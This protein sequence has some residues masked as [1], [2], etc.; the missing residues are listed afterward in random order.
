M[1]SFNS[2]NSI[3]HDRDP[4]TV[5]TDPTQ[6]CVET[7]DDA[8]KSGEIVAGLRSGEVGILY[9]QHGVGKTALMQ[10]L[11]YSLE[12]GQP[13]VPLTRAP[14]SPLKVCILTSRKAILSSIR[15]TRIRS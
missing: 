11:M 7:I 1:I 13:I 12:T 2:T 9:G 10:K 6:L 15:T 4:H 14:L 8:N 5:H 3:P